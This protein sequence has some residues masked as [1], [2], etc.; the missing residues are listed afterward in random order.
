M[1]YTTSI[2]ANWDYSTIHTQLYYNTVHIGTLKYHPVLYSTH[3]STVLL[4][5][6]SETTITQP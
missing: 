1:K 4:L 2:V 3:Y 5:L 6:H